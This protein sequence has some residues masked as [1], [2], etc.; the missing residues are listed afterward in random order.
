MGFFDS[1][2]DENNQHVDGI[3]ERAKFN[4]IL[5][6]AAKPIDIQFNGPAVEATSPTAGDI[7]SAIMIL[8]S[9]Q[10]HPVNLPG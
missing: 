8:A 2:S 3:L 1:L 7:V 5:I 4:S 6:I 10:P 9:S